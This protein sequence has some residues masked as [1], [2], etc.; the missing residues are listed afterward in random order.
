MPRSRFVR[1]ETD[2]I[3]LSE[4][5]T[6]TVRRRLTVG[7]RRAMYARMYKPDTTK[8]DPLRVESST[9]VAYLLDWS[10]VGDDGRKVPIEDLSPADLTV[11]IDGLEADDFRELADAIGEHIGRMDAERTAEKNGQ[12]GEIK[13]SPIS[14]SLGST[15]GVLTTS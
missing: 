2:T 4:G 15:D 14:P 13:S 7:E 1:P 3:K 12:A 6:I 5:D 11:V 10:F 8:V 9:V